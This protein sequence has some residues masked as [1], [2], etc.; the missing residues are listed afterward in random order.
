MVEYAKEKNIPVIA[1]NPP[2][3]YVTLV[4]R[5]GMKALDSLSADAKYFC[6]RNSSLE[7]F[8]YHNY[9]KKVALNIV[10]V[11]NVGRINNPQESMTRVI[12]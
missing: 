1:A 7:F 8:F 2:R 12:P 9:D 3:R 10:V 6:I 11:T 5:R 4:G